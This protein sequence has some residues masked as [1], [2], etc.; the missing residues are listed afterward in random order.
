MDEPEYLRSMCR[1]DGEA[2]AWINEARADF[3][4]LRFGVVVVAEAV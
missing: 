4:W 2:Y 3:D 1:P